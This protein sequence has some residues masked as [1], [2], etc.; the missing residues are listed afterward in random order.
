MKKLIFILLVTTS[1][2]SFADISITSEQIEKA[3]ADSKK[4]FK[5]FSAKKSPSSNLDWSKL[6]VPKIKYE[7]N[8]VDSAMKV[9]L[10]KQFDDPNYKIKEKI[11]VFISFSMPEESIKKYI[12]QANILGRDKISLV[13]I[14][15]NKSRNLK[16]T[17]EH[18]SRLTKGFNVEF[19]INPPAFERFDVKQVPA[20]VFYKDDPMYVASCNLK[21]QTSRAKK[22][23]DYLK[24]YGDVSIDYAIEYFM[25][26]NKTN[27]T[28][29]MNESYHK[30][31]GLK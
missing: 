7:G 3:K 11:K 4:A 5:D 22:A 10:V 25:R 8:L 2:S 19:Q 23:E 16:K 6:P 12:R 24:V 26:K 30:L 13:I 27:F 15:L 18:I 28:D 29:I 20:I 31:V 14:G 17:V 9:P 1:L 21:G